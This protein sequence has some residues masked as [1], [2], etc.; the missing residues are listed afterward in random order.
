MTK[1]ENIVYARLDTGYKDF[2]FPIALLEKIV[3][4]GF[5]VRSEYQDGE[6][7]LTE[8]HP[9]KKFSVINQDEVDAAKV[10]M[11]LSGD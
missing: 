4:E 9:I 10:Q 3:A 11:V 2:V 5:L 1:K 7:V 6:D 8:V